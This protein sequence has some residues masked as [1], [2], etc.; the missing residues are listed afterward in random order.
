MKRIVSLM[1]TALMLISVFMSAVV[2]A[3][4]D[5]AAPSGQIWEGE[6]ELR[7]NHYTTLSQVT[8]YAQDVAGYNTNDVSPSKPSCDAQAIAK[9]IEGGDELVIKLDVKCEGVQGFFVQLMRSNDFGIFDIYWDDQKLAS[10]VD[11]YAAKAERH[12][13]ELELGNH[14]VTKG[15]H[16]LRFVSVGKNESSSGY[17][18]G[19]DYFEMVG[20]D[21]V[22]RTLKYG[23]RNEET[24]R[25]ARKLDD[26]TIRYEG[27]GL[28]PT[29]ET[30]QLFPTTAYKTQIY[31]RED[32]FL[33]L[34]SHFFCN[35]MIPGDV[36]SFS[37]NLEEAGEYTAALG[38]MSGKDY[39]S[40]IWQID[41]NNMG[42]EVDQYSALFGCV[43]GYN[44]NVMLSAGEHTLSIICVGK[45]E[46]STNY[47]LSVDYL[48]LKKTGD[49]DESAVTTT[50]ATTEEA[51]TTEDKTTDE[52][53]T[54]EKVTVTDAPTE[55]D[56]TTEAPKD[57]TTTIG[58]TEGE[59]SGGCA[60]FGSFGA[61]IAAAVISLSF[62]A[63][64]VIKKKG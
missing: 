54:T 11:T 40:F 41:G 15:E 43:S 62:A 13:F 44:E 51:T 33:S 4:A 25:Q 10:N 23:E 29:D 48:D 55:S 45:N 35:S 59:E 24:W 50:E 3:S 12:F 60:G 46:S 16:T 17:L 64:A 26:G 9:L 20:I 32:A 18:I 34:G 36:F 21:N 30:K 37:F 56:I 61:V 57:N 5:E 42:A 63:V 1:L 39:G 22:R 6:S 7:R 38:A 47:V 52:V 49:Y 31:G 27:E 2:P 28:V 19:I 53:T 8:L 14:I 58:T